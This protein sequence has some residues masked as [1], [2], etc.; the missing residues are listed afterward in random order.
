M[1]ENIKNFKVNWIDGMKISK[2]HFQSLQDFA[3]ARIKDAISL[4]TGQDAYG[5]LPA[6]LSDNSD[7]SVTLD[8]HKGLTISIKKLRAVTLG[9]HRIEIT[10]QTLAVKENVVVEEFAEKDFEDGYV[11]LNVDVTNQIPFGEQY[12]RKFH[13]DTRI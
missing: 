10:Q 13:Q 4:H 8:V 9:G 5:L 7:L 11:L 12:P 3:D 2:E 6:H 1:I